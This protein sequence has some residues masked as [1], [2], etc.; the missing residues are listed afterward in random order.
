MQSYSLFAP[1]KINLH[2][3]VIGDRPDGYHEL[4]MI[5]QSVDLGDTLHLRA[6]GTDQ[7]RIFC[8][9]PQVPLDKTNLVYKAVRLMQKKY[10]K[11]SN[12]FGGL[13][14]TIEK[15]IPVAAGL[16]GGSSNAAAVL[17]G[18]N[19]IWSLGLTQPE[20][21]D[22]SAFLGSDVAFCISGGTAIATGRGEKITPL[23]DLKDIW[24]ILAKYNNLSV[25]TPRAYKSYRE[26]FNHL[27]VTDLEDINERTDHIHSGDLVRAISEENADKIGHLLMN[28]LEKVVLPQYPV[29]S[30][31]IDAFKAHNVLGAMM[32]GSGPTVFALCKTQKQAQM[33]TTNVKKE[34]NDANLDF[35]VTKMCP[36]GITV[37]SKGQSSKDKGQR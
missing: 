14:I 26:Q 19:L 12:N 16:A 3:E 17:V 22:L 33:V 4:V 5:M 21:R 32:S 10:S 29:V 1:A 18:I 25:S 27:Y 35:W 30:N 36:H 15:N 6:N 28:D 8:E 11:V 23:P 20:L 31:L 2:L 7:I 24:V 34:I 37:E 9:N 13:D